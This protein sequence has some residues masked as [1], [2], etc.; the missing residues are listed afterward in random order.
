MSDSGSVLRVIPVDPTSAERQARM[1]AKLGAPVK[2]YLDPQL[3][4]RLERCA[5]RQQSTLASLLRDA[6]E[7]YLED[8]EQDVSHHL[9]TVLPFPN[10]PSTVFLERGDRKRSRRTLR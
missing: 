8:H 6:L 2:A 4:E 3:R 9:Q 1:R 10:L 5:A 7:H